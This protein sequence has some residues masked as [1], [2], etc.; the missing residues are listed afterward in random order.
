M[1]SDIPFA[2]R[3]RGKNFSLCH[4]WRLRSW[5][6]LKHGLEL[7]FTRPPEKF[8]SYLVTDFVVVDD[9]DQVPDII[10]FYI[11]YADKDVRNFDA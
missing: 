9:F 10:D 2:S 1:P 6:L 11:V 3:S 7:H 4:H 5:S 8:H